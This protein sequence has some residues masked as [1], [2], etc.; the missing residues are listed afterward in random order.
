[1]A[2][3]PKVNLI[4]I[5]VQGA[6]ID[7]L[8]GMQEMLSSP[9]ARPGIILEFA[10][11]ELKRNG[12]LDEFFDFVAHN[13]YSLRAFIANERPHTKPPQI[14]RATLRRIAE[15]FI[16]GGDPAEFDLLLLPHP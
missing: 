3:A 10:P 11:G 1:M 15:D 2:K 9:G 4:K 13:D 16:A 7:V 6:Q 12:T 8:R 14:R 5:D